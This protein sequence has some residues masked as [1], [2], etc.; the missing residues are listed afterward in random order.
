M[1]SKST[2]VGLAVMSFTFV[3]ICLAAPGVGQERLDVAN[4]A[5][6]IDA[7]D[8]VWIEEL[9]MME[10]RDAIQEGK[11]TAL[12]LTGGIE[13]NGPYLATGKHNYVLKVM[14][15]SIARELGNALVAPIVTLEPGDPERVRTAGTIYLSRE[16]Y[17]AVL[18]DMATSLKTQ[19]FTDVFLLGDSGGPTKSRCKRSSH[20]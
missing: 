18:R 10:V 13:E 2:D 11:T 14:G 17:K 5:R 7:L 6:P 16:T 4:M 8:S 12:I 15:E 3:V 20:R 1:W 9:T 19:G